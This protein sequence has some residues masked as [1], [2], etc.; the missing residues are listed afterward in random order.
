MFVSVCGNKIFGVI[1]FLHDRYAYD[2]HPQCCNI[3]VLSRN[4]SNFNDTLVGQ[5]ICNAINM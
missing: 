5:K 4:F 1:R 3:A 2:S